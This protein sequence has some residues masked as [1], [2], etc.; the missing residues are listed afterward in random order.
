[1]NKICSHT[2]RIFNISN[3]NDLKIIFNERSLTKSGSILSGEIYW[4]FGKTFFPD[5]GWNDIVSVILGQWTTSMIS[6][7]NG[8]ITWEI[9][10]YM[11]GHCK[12]KIY[13]YNKNLLLI[14]CYNY[15]L[16]IEPVLV[17][18]VD[19]KIVTRKLLLAATRFLITCETIVEQTEYLQRDIQLIKCNCTKLKAMLKLL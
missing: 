10:E 7:L 15:S 5:E 3:K 11:D 13:P 16:S 2:F 9:F 12:L 17:C 6:L 19:A 1:M 8:G 18:Q 4:L 14:K